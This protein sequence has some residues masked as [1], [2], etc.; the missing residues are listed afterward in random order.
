M[1][2]KTAVKNLD[3]IITKIEF[4]RLQV[5]NH[6]IVQLIAIS[7]YSTAEDIKKLYESGQRAFG[8]NKVQD[9]KSKQEELVD[10]PIAWHFVGSLQK[11]KINNLIDLN[12]IL[13]HF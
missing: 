13:M 10:L 3:T 9:L 8:E 6:K 4:S 12:P 1:T 7:K 11:N 5:D 2:K